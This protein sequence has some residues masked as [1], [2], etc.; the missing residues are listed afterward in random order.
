MHIP[1]ILEKDLE[2]QE[3]FYVPRNRMIVVDI[4]FDHQNCIFL[5]YVGDV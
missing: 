3:Y 5:N 1:T 2:K 4:V